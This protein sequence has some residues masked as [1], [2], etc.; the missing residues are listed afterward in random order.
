MWLLLCLCEYYSR[1]HEQYYMCVCTLFVNYITIKQL[2]MVYG[3]I[4]AIQMRAFECA[5]RTHTLPLLLFLVVLPHRGWMAADQFS[6]SV[7]QQQTRDTEYV[8]NCA[9]T[10]QLRERMQMTCIWI[11]LPR[12]HFRSINNGINSEYNWWSQPGYAALVNTFYA[13]F[14]R[15]MAIATLQ[16]TQLHSNDC[17]INP[18]R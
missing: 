1:I 11:P 2:R 9:C 15:T 6:P 12:A 4:E 7:A 14:K 10:C 18:D 17:A 13:L 8:G 3:M 16:P 5:S